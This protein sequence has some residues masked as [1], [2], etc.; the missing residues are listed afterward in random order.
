MIIIEGPD[1]S[2]KS[3]LAAQLRRDTGLP[4]IQSSRPSPDLN[5][6]QVYQHCLYQVAPKE[7]LAILDRVTAISESIY[8]PICRGES[9]LG[10][11]QRD[12]LLDVWNRPYTV[13]YCRPEDSVILDNKG[14]DQM[15]GVLEN[16]QAIIAAYDRLMDDLARFG[17]PHVSV[18]DWKDKLSYISVLNLVEGCK[19]Q[20]MSAVQSAT[21][22]SM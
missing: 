20:H 15:P 13:I 14:R 7:K 2:G 10:M 18:Y 5:F 1:N 9:A 12:A 11:Y 16:H 19:R 6:V 8:G 17:T 3:T 4:V 22:M 21:F